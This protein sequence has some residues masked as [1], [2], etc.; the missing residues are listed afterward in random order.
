MKSR[1]LAAPTAEV[2]DWLW[3]HPTKISRATEKAFLTWGLCVALTLVRTCH[4][5]VDGRQQFETALKCMASPKYHLWYQI[6]PDAANTAVHVSEI[7]YDLYTFEVL[8][9][10]PSKE[11]LN[12]SFLKTLLQQ[13]YVGPSE[14][15]TACT[16]LKWEQLEMSFTGSLGGASIPQW[17]QQLGTG[18]ARILL[19]R[20]F[21]VGGC[22][23][24]GPFLGPWYNTAPSNS[25]KW[26]H[27]FENPSS[28]LQALKL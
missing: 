4:F 8:L 23:N 17:F 9:P 12:T 10:S 13:G 16:I 11:L 22:Q 14:T 19:G 21:P 27:N 7:A 15:C 3:N 1:I 2:K 25:P 20:C 26:G 28:H 18:N 5:C 6:L 24:Y